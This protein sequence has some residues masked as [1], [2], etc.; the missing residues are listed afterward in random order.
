MKIETAAEYRMIARY[1]ARQAGV[2]EPAWVRM[3]AEALEDYA[4][5]S[6]Q[7]GR[8]PARELTKEEQRAEAIL[9]TDDAEQLVNPLGD[10]RLPPLLPGAR[11]DDKCAS[12]A[13]HVERWRHRTDVGHD[14]VEVE[15]KPA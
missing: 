14:F 2:G 4:R 1:C 10:P 13:C 9:E 11:F 3:F 6:V 5:R 7:A 8:N 15:Y 12:E